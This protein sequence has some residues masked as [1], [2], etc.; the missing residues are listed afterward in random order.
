M[1]EEK[2]QV[3]YDDEI[4]LMDLFKCVWKKK[5]F[6][7]KVTIGFL[8]LGLVIVFSAKVEYKASA[9]LM[10]ESQNGMSPDLG[11]LGGLVGLAGINFNMNGGGSLTPELYPEII[12]SSIFVEKLSNTPVYFEKIDSTLSG[13]DYF[14]DLDRSSLIGFIFEYSIGLPWKI[15]DA[16]SSPIEEVVLTDYDLVR[17][18]KADWKIMEAYAHRLSVFVDSKTGII[19]VESEM[20]DPVAAAMTANLLVKSLTKSIITY[21]VEKAEISLQ[22]VQER[23]QEAKQNYEINQS[24]LATFTDRNQNISN[25]IVQTEYVR[26]QN[27]MN[28]SFEV[29]KGL[30]TQL[31]QAKIQVK[32]ETPVFTVLEPV[33]IPVE[34]SKPK[35]VFTVIISAFIGVVFGVLWTLL[36]GF[37]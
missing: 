10:A 7:A 25:A 29:Y 15:M 26:L 1:G 11:G 6:V 3:S 35:V 36:K 30:A 4:D 14:R 20:P 27:Q 28:I 23:F 16:F 37:S 17:Y 13:F 5:L 22:F 9:K 32:E 2:Q 19:T 34:K 8:L 24:K 12:K 21:K 33:K 31:E 18:S